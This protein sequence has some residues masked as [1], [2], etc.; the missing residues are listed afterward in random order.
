LRRRRNGVGDQRVAGQS[1]DIL[2]GQS[3]GACTGRD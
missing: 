3:L 1:L 2:V